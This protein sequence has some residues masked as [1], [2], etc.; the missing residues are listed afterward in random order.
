PTNISNGHQLSPLASPT[1][2]S[3]GN[4]QFGVNLVANTIGCGAPANFGAPAVQVPDNTFSYGAVEPGYNT[5]G[6][7]KYVKGDTV[8]SSTNSSGETDFTI[9]FIYN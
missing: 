9:S 1:A 8:A 7:F 6:L 4:E 3:V 2:S 5:C